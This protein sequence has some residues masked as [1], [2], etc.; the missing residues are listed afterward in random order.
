MDRHLFVDAAATA[1]TA[2][3]INRRCAK[4]R[5]DD[6]SRRLVDRPACP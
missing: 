5:I 3:I 4:G 2:A 6:A 1:T